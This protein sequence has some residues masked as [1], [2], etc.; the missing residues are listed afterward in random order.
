MPYALILAG[1]VLIVTGAR[2][3]QGCLFSYLQ[4]D[5]TG[6]DNFTYWLVAVTI[7]GALGYIPAFQKV[8]IAFLTL[9]L[10]SL[11]VSNRSGFSNL[12]N[13]LASN[14]SSAPG[15]NQLNLGSNASSILSGSQQQ[16]S[17]PLLGPLPQ[18]PNLGSSFNG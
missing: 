17:T 16:P 11:V 6:N 5:L 15:L 1:I 9:I 3:T 4:N 8:S 7:V 13:A 18:L 10:I 2:G 12:V 14:A